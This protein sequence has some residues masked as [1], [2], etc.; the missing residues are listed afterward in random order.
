MDAA[1]AARVEDGVAYIHADADVGE[2]FQDERLHVGSPRPVRAFDR[3]M[4]RLDS[5]QSDGVWMWSPGSQRDA[6]R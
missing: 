4:D 5:G 2:V 1:S 6:R 3:L